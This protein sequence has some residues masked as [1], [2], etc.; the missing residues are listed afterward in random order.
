MKENTSLSQVKVTCSACHLR[1]LCLPMGLG[2]AEL[3]RIDNRLNLR[4]TINRQ[5]E[6][7]AVGDLFAAVYA[8]RSGFFK[9]CIYSEDGREQVMGFH[10]AGEILGFDGISHDMH[11]VTAIAL[12]DSQVCVI[13]YEELENI[14]REFEGL[15]RHL[16]R[17]MSREIVADQQVMLLLGHMR[18]EERLAAF[19]LNLMQRLHSR[20]FSSSEVV[21][22]MTRQEIGSYLGLTLETV[23]R[24]FSQLQD[25]GVLEVNQRRIRI[26]DQL[27]LQQLAPN[28]S[29]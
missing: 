27:A 7:F 28:L 10:M 20:G 5:A 26:K 6:L 9:T 14:S 8:I 13:P 1:E 2:E 17:L 23:S 12:E 19:L 11:N 29:C 15:Q 16:H 22:R 21:L 3:E 24:L 18:S 4:R 25:E